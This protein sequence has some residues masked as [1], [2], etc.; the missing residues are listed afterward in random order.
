MTVPAAA[1]PAFIELTNQVVSR[2]LQTVL[3]VDDEAFIQRSELI[4][5]PGV[6]LREPGP[7][8]EVD[9]MPD[10]PATNLPDAKRPPSTGHL[11]DAKVLVDAFAEHG[12]V[13]AVMA[14]AAAEELIPQI[15]RVAAATDVVVLDWKIAKSNGDIALTAIARI[16]QA[17]RE[18]GGRLRLI[19]IYTGEPDIENIRDTVATRFRQPAEASSKSIQI[20]NVRIAFRRKAG[21]K[22]VS[23]D[24]EI[25]EKDLPAAIRD[26]FV[27]FVGGLLPNAAMTAIAAVRE[28]AHRVLRRFSGK[29][30]GAYLSRRMLLPVPSDAE[31]YLF[32]LIG[33]ELKTLFD[34]QFIA[35]T[36]I[37]AEVVF[38][39]I[40]WKNAEG[41]M[42][43]LDKEAQSIPAEEVKRALIEGIDRCDKNIWKTTK[44]HEKI[45]SLLHETPAIGE[46]AHLRFSALSSLRR[47]VTYSPLQ[48]PP[49]F[50]TLGTLLSLD[51]DV[52]EGPDE[53][54]NAQSKAGQ[55]GPAPERETVTSY[56]VCLQPLC[57]CL[58]LAS[59]EKRP[60]L[61]GALKLA[62]KNFDLVVPSIDKGLLRLKFVST[63]FKSEHVRFTGEAHG[64]VLAS[65]NES[66]HSW[67]FVDVDG[68]RFQWLG[69]LRDPF[70]QR[71]IQRLAS[72]L[73]RVGL[74]EFEWQ[75]RHA[76]RGGSEV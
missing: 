42:W 32:D 51:E 63:P 23:T 66:G 37:G 62:D 27:A 14:P 29:L 43:K 74:A 56:Y 50:L 65:P 75:R 44:I 69:E 8:G 38:D 64:V 55:Q 7:R 35:A 72:Q 61:F 54:G 1:V 70:A 33:D 45:H 4:T 58:R 52:H 10:S 22:E 6:D 9:A 5:P 71:F 17:D 13:C 57:D 16:V 11:L 39:Y 28:Q 30:D 26:E 20:D 46:D 49:P 15:E 73:G 68:R 34:D 25:V 36:C 19:L 47:D 31:T 60:F 3:V 40:N 24:S 48:K 12:L 76:G 2:F 53:E 18:H 41:S 67:A 21:G 59:G